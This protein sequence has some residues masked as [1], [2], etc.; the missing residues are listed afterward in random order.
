MHNFKEIYNK[1]LAGMKDYASYFEM[2]VLDSE[3]IRAFV[4]EVCK[5]VCRKGENDG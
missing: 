1:Q 4:Y 2:M 5:A 3:F